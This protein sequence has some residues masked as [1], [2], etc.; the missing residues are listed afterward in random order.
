MRGNIS[1]YTIV[2]DE[3]I[4]QCDGFSVYYEYELTEGKLDAN[5]WSVWVRE[6]GTTWV[7]V[8][9]IKVENKVG[10]VY[11]ISFDYPITFNEIWIMPET[12]SFNY[13]VIPTFQIG[14]LLF[15]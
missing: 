7:R 13:S 4:V 6:D 1:G 9:D 2:S 15:D 5:A 8:Q 3:M 14:Y 12:Y 10:E 11:D